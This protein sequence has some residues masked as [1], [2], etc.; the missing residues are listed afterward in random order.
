MLYDLIFQRTYTY[1]YNPNWVVDHLFKGALI[2]IDTVIMN[3]EWL[4]F[5]LRG[6]I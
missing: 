1:T 6:L 2:R 5:S 4:D 3:I